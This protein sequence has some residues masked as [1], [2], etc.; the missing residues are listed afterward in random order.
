[1][2][3][4]SICSSSLSLRAHWIY[5]STPRLWR[6]SWMHITEDLVISKFKTFK[7]NSRTWAWSLEYTSRPSK[8][9]QATRPTSW[10]APA[11]LVE[12]FVV[13]TDAGLAPHEWRARSS[14]HESSIKF[15][16][17]STSTTS[18][19][20]PTILKAQP[21]SLTVCTFSVAPSWSS[22]RRRSRGVW[23]ALPELA[24]IQ[25]HPS[26]SERWARHV[27]TQA[28][29]T[30]GRCASRI[31]RRSDIL[32]FFL[33]RSRSWHWWQAEKL[34][35][36]GCKRDVFTCIRWAKKR[37]SSNGDVEEKERAEEVE[38]VWQEWL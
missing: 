31:P 15:A 11:F 37:H 29:S 9:R 8:S 22:K 19:W 28:A 20:A 14:G 5:I 10:T 36:C 27:G 38:D 2:G 1:M 7:F 16:W 25:R 26:I 35:L 4:S 21:P 30:L 32:F 17:P 13:E 23:H 12:P 3:T 6:S 34:S 18:R 33:R 24:A